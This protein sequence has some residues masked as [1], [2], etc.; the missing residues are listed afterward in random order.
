MKHDRIAA[1]EHASDL[2]PIRK[3]RVIVGLSVSLW[4]LIGAA[5]LA[6]RG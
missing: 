5:V 6:F 2:T 4:L 1:P 3:M